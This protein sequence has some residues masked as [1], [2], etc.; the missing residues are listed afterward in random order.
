[1]AKIP[2]VKLPK[3]A[4]AGSVVQIKTLASHP[5]ETGLRKDKKGKPIPR[6]ILNNFSCSLNGKELFGAD[7]FTSVSANPYISFFITAKESGSYVFKWTDDNG[8]V[9]SVSKDM[10]VS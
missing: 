5:M 1:M 7:M 3:K 6:L 9:I 8:E 2:R 4:K 10:A